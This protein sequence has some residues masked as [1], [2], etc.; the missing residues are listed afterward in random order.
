MI[1]FF[2][3]LKTPEELH[4]TFTIYCW[5][6]LLKLGSLEYALFFFSCSA[7]KFHWT[8]T[9]QVFGC[10]YGQT[11]TDEQINAM[12]WS[13]KVHYLKRNP[14]TVARQS[15]YV[16]RQLWGKVISS[17]MHTIGQIWNFDDR[18]EFENRGTEHMH[19]QIHVVDAPKIDE[20]KSSE[21]GEFIDK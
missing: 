21:V 20:N 14:V 5:M 13:T 15:D 10:Q 17:V 9:I 18:R 2:L 19:A 3:P 6:S 12:D 4:S 7:A 11:L 8:E 1:R 16:F